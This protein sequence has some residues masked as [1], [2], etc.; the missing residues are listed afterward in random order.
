MTAGYRPWLDGV[1][2]L[3]ILLVVVE[4]MGIGLLPDWNYGGTG[5]GIFF[6]LSGYLITGLLID[7]FAANGSI[8]LK[9]FYLRRAARLVPALLLLVLICD[10]F[11]YFMGW[12]DEVISSFLALAYVMNYATLWVGHYLPAFGHTWSLAVEE[13][14][15]LLWPLVLL[16]L[17]RRRSMQ[18]ILRVAL[19]VCAAGLAWR[20]SIVELGA[21]PRLA[22]VGSLERA[23]TLLFGAAAAIATRLDWRPRPIYLPAGLAMIALH[24][25]FSPELKYVNASLLGGGTAL[26]LS[27]LDACD[28]RRTRAVFSLSPLVW[29]GSISYGLYLWHAVV[30]HSAKRLGY[31]DWWGKIGA[32]ALALLIAWGSFR[33]VER[34]ARERVRA[35]LK[36]RE[37]SRSSLPGIHPDLVPST[38]KPFPR[39]AVHR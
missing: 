34:P 17:L 38:G 1:R 26:M 13:H 10:P 6:V 21:P 29:L 36:S 20:A 8:C 33:C 31:W 18:T 35:W 12:R 15:Y 5:V 11:F 9:A 30:L 39:A 28:I 3:S 24:L 27:A 7:E 19:C 16:W 32:V 2:G 23:D 4:H 37:S 14:F 22:Y 25:C